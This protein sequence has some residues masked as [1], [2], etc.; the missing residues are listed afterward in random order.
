LLLAGELEPLGS[1]RCNQQFPHRFL[2][3]DT[4]V[5]ILR[6]QVTG[7]TS[8]HNLEMFHQ[9]AIGIMAYSRMRQVALYSSKKKSY[10]GGMLI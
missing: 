3:Q 1:R 5:P 10:N 6:L 7:A 2:I 4:I 9:E 8:V